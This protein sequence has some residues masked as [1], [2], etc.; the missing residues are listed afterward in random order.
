[1]M[2]FALLL[3]LSTLLLSPLICMGRLRI[4]PSHLQRLARVH[5]HIVFIKET[6]L[7]YT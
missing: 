6:I 1:M 3:L 5:M 4:P 7:W 2:G